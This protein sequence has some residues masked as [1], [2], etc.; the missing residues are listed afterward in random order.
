M[1][2]KCIIFVGVFIIM[3]C[4]GKM[5]NEVSSTMDKRKKSVILFIISFLIFLALFVQMKQDLALVWSGG[6]AVIVT[7]LEIVT[8]KYLPF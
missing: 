5:I 7:V 4:I 3:L 2:S 1:V 6:M 8:E